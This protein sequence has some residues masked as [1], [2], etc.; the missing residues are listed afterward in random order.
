[1]TDSVVINSAPTAGAPEG[2]D[3]KMMDLVDKANTPQTENLDQ[4]AD[5]TTNSEERPQWL[6]EK[7]KT[8][9]DLAKAYAE[10]ES[11]IGK[12]PEKAPEDKPQDLPDPTKATDA[13]VDKTLADRGLNLADFS[14]E[15]AE[16]GELSPESYKKLEAAGIDKNTVDLYIEGQKALAVQF[17]TSVK[18]EVGGDETYA[19]MVD[20]AKSNL[21]P[22]EINAFNAA[23]SSGNI[24][25]AKLAVLGLQARYTSVNGSEPKKVIG[26]KASTTADVFESTAQ[27][28]AAMRDPRYKTDPAYR[29]DVQAKLAR[30]SV[31]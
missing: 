30:S 9:E 1:M 24:D 2:H 4:L 19:Q 28:T 22:S 12:Q 26:G 25:Q 8:P 7:F 23:V 16:K 20:W 10:L 5:T 15:F 6:P 27:L 14:A 18:A 31:F 29:A 17:E 13:E 3:Q 21:S 11:K